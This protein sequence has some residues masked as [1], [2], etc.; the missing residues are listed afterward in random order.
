[1]HAAAEGGSKNMFERVRGALHQAFGPEKVGTA[2]FSPIFI[3]RNQEG[4]WN[5][6]K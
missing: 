3:Q 1:M 5:F 4:T 2:Y 6:L